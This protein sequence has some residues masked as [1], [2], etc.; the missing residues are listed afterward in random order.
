MS[1]SISISPKHS[2]IKEERDL[3]QLKAQ[4]GLIGPDIVANETSSSPKEG[5]AKRHTSQMA[6]GTFILAAVVKT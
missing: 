2:S 1:E 6:E 4:T 3:S 5:M